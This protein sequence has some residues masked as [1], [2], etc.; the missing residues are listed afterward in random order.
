MYAIGAF[1]TDAVSVSTYLL[2]Q[3]MVTSA[4]LT[5]HYVNEFADVKVDRLVRHRTLFSGGSGVLA[6]GQLTRP[7]ALAAALVTTASTV[8]LIIFIEPTSTAAA[9][10]GFLALTISW[11][12][13]LRP[14][15]LLDTGFG[16]ATTSLV[17]TV[18][19]P[20]VGASTQ[21]ADIA[22][23]LI[24]VVFSLFPVHLAMMLTFELPDL[25]T[26]KRAHKNVLAVRMGE[27]RTRRAVSALLV[28]SALVV[29]SAVII[30]SVEQVALW[31]VVASAVP[32][33]L[34][35]KLIGGTRYALLTASAVSTL[36]V[37]GSGLLVTVIL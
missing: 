27:P 37:L 28:L 34:L 24:W 15:R 12:Y 35:V 16:E 2:G 7:V 1:T 19:V 23:T 10:L 8:V 31:A 33:V 5:A 25:E 30:G 13:S 18:F 17:V 11:A 22:T 20:L 32:A 21:G 29:I 6:S 14:L 9:L 26:D 4:Q 36:V 3:G